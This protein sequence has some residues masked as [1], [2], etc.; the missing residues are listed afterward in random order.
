MKK[1]RQTP[2][3]RCDTLATMKRLFIGGLFLLLVNL[4]RADDS[5]LNAG[6]EGPAP[7]NVKAG[8]QSKVRMVSEQ[9]EFHFSTTK[10]SVIATFHFL[11]T[12]SAPIR[13]TFGF[14]DEGLPARIA[15]KGKEVPEG[16]PGAIEDMQSFVDGKKVDSKVEL[17]Y[18][19]WA[20]G[21]ECWLP[22]TKKDEDADEMAWHTLTVNFP[23]G[24]EMVVQRRYSVKDGDQN[25]GV[26]F[27]SYTVHTGSSWQGKIGKLNATVFLEGGLTVDDL[28][29]TE[30]K[31]LG[32][33]LVTPGRREW[34]IVSPKEM[35]MEWD[36]FKP[37][38]EKGKQFIQISARD[39]KWDAKYLKDV[40]FTSDPYSQ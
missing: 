18:V 29:W 14:P 30:K 34:K 25:G 20:P 6:A 13:Q 26:Y 15:S 12:T 35:T 9:L 2:T 36:N 17:G 40:S 38:D 4:A 8:E 16:T 10:T 22:A 7:L 24:K 31:L 3:R 33:F 21:H 32:T 27:F 5:T 37:S 23:P 11:N 19:K 28:G 39:K 1:L